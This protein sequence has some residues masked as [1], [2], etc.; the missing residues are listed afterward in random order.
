MNFYEKN[1]KS[2]KKGPVVGLVLFLLLSIF[3]CAVLIYY[4]FNKSKAIESILKAN[5]D[6]KIIA[7]TAQQKKL[8]TKSDGSDE[9]ISLIKKNTDKKIK[10]AKI[11]H[12]HLLKA[13]YKK[14]TTLVIS[15]VMALL[16][17]T[18]IG[19]VFVLVFNGF[20]GHWEFNHL[21]HDFKIETSMSKTTL[22]IDGE[23]QDMLFEAG[24]VGT[25]RLYG[26]IDIDSENKDIDIENK[27]IDSGDKD[28][29]TKIF[30]NVKV[31]IG[32]GTNSRCAVFIDNRLVFP[33]K[34]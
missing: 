1:S 22:E 24:Q 27:D 5:L 2:S 13:S 33:T 9:S 28:E 29:F 21:G 25:K 6:A 7:L 20:K 23:L 11:E 10:A 34:D 30:G 12:N 19:I 8:I 4:N 15:I 26:K 18:V 14:D 17:F 3:I 32:S 31:S 16:F